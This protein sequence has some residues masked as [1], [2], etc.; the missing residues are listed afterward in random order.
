MNED[1]M[2]EYL[3]MES[4]VAV[5]SGQTPVLRRIVGGVYLEAGRCQLAA[6]MYRGG[7]VTRRA[8]GRRYGDSV[9]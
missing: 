5:S 7:D 2:K 3:Q 4:V 8:A 9:V 6:T 1:I